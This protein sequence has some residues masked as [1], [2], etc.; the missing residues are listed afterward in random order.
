[1]LLTVLAG[2]ATSPST[3]QT[4][5][6]VVPPVSQAPPASGAGGLFGSGLSDA[7]EPQRTRLQ[8]A[9][10]G[11]PVV[12]EATAERALRVAV[13]LKNSFEPG[14]AA[15]RPALAAVLDQLAT[16]FKPYAATAELRIAT[17]D[18]ADAKVAGRLPKERSASVRD[19]LVGRGVP[20]SRIAALGAVTA[21]ETVEV[22]I[23]DRPLSAS[24]A[25]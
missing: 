3:S 13:P 16:G 8:S 6:G 5:P 2:C 24:P 19:Y 17:P 23:A 25:R 7:L 1:L 14:R 20:I 10:K 22:L 11:T 4:T 15:V 9:L 18:D 12:V 21:G